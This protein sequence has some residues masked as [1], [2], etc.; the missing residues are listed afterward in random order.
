MGKGTRCLLSQIE[1][2]YITDIISHI[3]V[4]EGIASGCVKGNKKAE[5]KQQ[6]Q[7]IVV[8]YFMCWN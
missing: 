6:Q 8:T 4:N 7:N 3:G 1:G 5:E 2:A